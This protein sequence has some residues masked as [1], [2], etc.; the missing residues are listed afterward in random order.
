[1]LNKEINDALKRLM[2]CAL[3]LLGI[4]VAFILDNIIFKF[5][6]SL[7]DT[8]ETTLII[9]AF[10]YAFYAGFTVFLSEKKDNAFEYLLSLPLPKVK[11]L[12][13][14]VIPR[15][16]IL[17]ILILPLILIWKF[18]PFSIS[19][20]FLIFTFFISLFLSFAV[21]SILLGLIGVVLLHSLIS[22]HMKILNFLFWKNQVS[23][24]GVNPLLIIISSF[25]VLFPLG[26]AFWLVIRQF[27]LK[28]IKL[29]LKPYYYIA[30]PAI[31]IELIFLVWFYRPYL[32]WFQNG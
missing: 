20:M 19:G 1:M 9:T 16:I 27:D 4:P 6:W 18:N 31:I 12:F 21:D 17:F 15:L 3:I 22:F 26:L 13:L 5:G 29:Q 10:A 7:S 24:H 14:K 25:L 8:M 2:E 23:T 30:I 32:N 11:I 28:P